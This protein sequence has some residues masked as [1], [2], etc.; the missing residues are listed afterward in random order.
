MI[1][2]DVLKGEIT[3]NGLSQRKVAKHLGMSDKTFY[4][5]MKK[6]IFDSDEICEMISLL[7]L[8]DP[9]SIFLCNKSPCK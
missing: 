6:G 3:R 2:T 7:K 1:K 5:K 4:D 9:M 8:S